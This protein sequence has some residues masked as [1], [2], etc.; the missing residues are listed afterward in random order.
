MILACS[1]LL[2]GVFVWGKKVREGKYTEFPCK[3]EN[4]A[5][6]GKFLVEQ[7]ELA[8]NE[9]GLPN[10]IKPSF[11]DNDRLNYKYALENAVLK[12]YNFNAGGSIYY[13][14]NSPIS[15]LRIYHCADSA[16]VEVLERFSRP[17]EGNRRAVIQNPKTDSQLKLLLVAMST[18]NN[19]IAASSLKTFTFFCDPI[20]RFYAGY[21]DSIRRKYYK[22]VEKNTLKNLTTIKQ[23]I[24]Q[25]LSYEQPVPATYL[26][27]YSM[28]GYYLDFHVDVFGHMESLQ[29]D[30]STKI[31]P[32]Y[33]LNAQAS[34]TREAFSKRPLPDIYGVRSALDTLFKDDPNYLRALCH[35][36]LID[37]VCL[38]KY[39]LPAACAHLQ[40]LR[41]GAQKALKEGRLLPFSNNVL[42]S[43]NG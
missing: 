27:L 32:L 25:L 10:Q 43:F 39:A 21:Q 18:L 3:P 24:Q 19:S 23:H 14:Q 8:R 15:Y 4:R 22:A 9:I 6:M 12:F 40:S 35:A 26:N 31:C 11:N 42:K 38:P 1:I 28:S 30:W 2:M 37:Y 13:K 29:E 34:Y 7:W 16:I 20:Q 5:L 36:Y 41:E 17:Q 33:G